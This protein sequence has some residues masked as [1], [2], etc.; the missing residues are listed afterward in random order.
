MVY[1]IISER[2]KE[3][4]PRNDL[5]T[6]LMASMHEDGTQMT[7]KQLRDE[8]MTLFVA[9]H[10]TTALS[11][12]WTWYLLSENPAAEARLHE[13]LREVL[14]GRPAETRD[15]GKVAVSQRRGA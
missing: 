3:T 14:G 15:L 6:L 4:Q 1:R 10:E 8:T 12:S 9:G 13:E 5:L 7:E 11:L 2:K